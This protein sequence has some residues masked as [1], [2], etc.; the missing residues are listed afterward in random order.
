MTLGRKDGILV[1]AEPGVSPGASEPEGWAMSDAGKI[2]V[3][4]SVVVG[5]TL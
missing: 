3:D 5:V 4:V 2:W 1:G